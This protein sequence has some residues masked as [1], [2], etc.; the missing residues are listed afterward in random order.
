MNK[1]ND[2]KIGSITYRGTTFDIMYRPSLKDTVCLSEWRIDKY[3]NLIV[4][5]IFRN[6]IH[7]EDIK[8]LIYHELYH[9]YFKSTNEFQADRFACSIV[10]YDKFEECI[11][12]YCRKY[13]CDLLKYRSSKSIYN[14]YCLYRLNAVRNVAQSISD[15]EIYKSYN[16]ELI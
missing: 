7:N 5:D 8:P 11:N 13:L 2:I 16:L 4:G 9:L 6:N 15:I 14:S 1:Y 12:K 3:A 10:G